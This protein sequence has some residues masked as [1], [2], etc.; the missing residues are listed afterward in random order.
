MRKALSLHHRHAMQMISLLTMLLLTLIPLGT[1]AADIGAKPSMDFEFE[2][3]T[4]Q[5]LHIV[6]GTLLECSSVDCLDAKP[7][8]EIGP[9][10][11]TCDENSCS[12]IAYGYSDYHRLMIQFS[13]GKTRASNVFQ[14]DSFFM[15][16]RVI[17]R[18]DD[19]IV[20]KIRGKSYH[21][22]LT[23]FGALFGGLLA[24]LLGIII[25][26]LLAL[27]IVRSGEGKA[28]FSQSRWIFIS[29]WLAMGI[30]TFLVSFISI[31]V[32]VTIAIEGLLALLYAILRKRSK[33]TTLTMVSLANLVTVPIFWFSAPNTIASNY[34]IFTI[35]GEIV[36]W[37]MESAILYLTQRDSTR[38]QEML[39]LSLILNGCSFLIGLLLHI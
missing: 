14:S 19:L 20:E 6:E 13:D 17:V 18:E 37:L 38:F 26:I 2:Y 10:G 11:L 15:T 12:A 9:Q 31:A 5:P 32:P 39:L 4:S 7:L 27:I 36:I 33:I 8:Q 1:A 28:D 29:L 35:I 16:Y 21:P 3:E 22:L 23:I 24:I 34:I 25:L 30:F